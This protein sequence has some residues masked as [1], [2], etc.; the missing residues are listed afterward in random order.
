MWQAPW[1]NTLLFV[2]FLY[3][4][5]AGLGI[6]G[7]DSIFNTMPRGCKLR[8]K[9][10]GSCLRSMI[11]CQS[12]FPP[13]EHALLGSTNYCQILLTNLTVYDLT[14]NHFIPSWT[15]Q[16]ISCG[17]KTTHSHFDTPNHIFI[18]EIKECWFCTPLCL[19]VVFYTKIDGWNRF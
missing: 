14:W 17:T 3:H 10:F 2:H 8:V 19:V 5:E 11:L 12:F 15:T 7:A 6:W 4:K 9:H 13:I 16:P 1:I 18:N